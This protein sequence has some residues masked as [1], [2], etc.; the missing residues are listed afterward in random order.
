MLVRDFS[1]TISQYENFAIWDISDMDDFFSGNGVLTEIFETE[2]KM[3]LAE[4]KQRRAE[5]VETDPGLIASILDMVADKHFFLFTL[6]DKN[7]MELIRMQQEGIMNFG[8]DI[9]SIN[10]D[11]Y[12][13]MMMDKVKQVSMGI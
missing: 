12:Y 13:A 2:Y 11:H 7:H 10:G 4:F 9:A 6:H 8:V 3:P 1:N 5:I